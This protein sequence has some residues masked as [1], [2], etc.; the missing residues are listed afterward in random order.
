MADDAAASPRRYRFNG[1]W[2]DEPVGV[3]DEL[4]WL[5][6]ERQDR[7]ERYGWNYPA[8]DVVG[9]GLHR[10]D[11]PLDR[12]APANAGIASRCCG[13]PASRVWRVAAS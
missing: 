3:R 13:V 2:H 5:G 7:Y 1:V 4:A 9:T 12:L 6:P 10:T 8:I 11:I